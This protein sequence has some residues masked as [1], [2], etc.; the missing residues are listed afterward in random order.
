MMSNF[1]LL[2]IGF[3]DIFPQA[4]WQIPGLIVVIGA[5]IGLVIYR[6]RQM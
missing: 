2:A 6:R 4:E 3:R 1:D 5:I